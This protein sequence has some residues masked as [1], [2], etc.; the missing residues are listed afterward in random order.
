MVRG[1]NFK[2]HY[3]STRLITLFIL[4]VTSQSVLAGNGINTKPGAGPA[5]HGYDPVAYF[6]NGEP[7]Q[8]SEAYSYNHQGVT[9]QFS[10]EENKQLFIGS[11][12]S[13]IPQYGG[14]CAYAASRNYIADADP[15]A[16]T[17]DDGK[18]YLNYSLSVRETWLGDR[19]SN[20]S[21]AD[22]YWPELVEKAQ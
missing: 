6:V 22:G 7:Q 9:W 14:F 11:P 3:Q 10:N 5:I 15:V 17:I 4:I 2:I 8:G 13:Y 20:I 1:I 21:K 16:W 19:K 18:L 12:E